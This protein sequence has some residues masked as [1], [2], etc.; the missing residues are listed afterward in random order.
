VIIES[1]RYRRRSNTL[2]T[3]YEF[4]D[5]L[6]LLS[7]CTP[8]KKRC[9]N[10]TPRVYINILLRYCVCAQTHFYRLMCSRRS[11]K[12]RASINTHHMCVCAIFFCYQ[13][14]GQRGEE[15]HITTTLLLQSRRVTRRS[16]AAWPKATDR[17]AGSGGGGGGRRGYKNG[18][19]VLHLIPSRR[20]F[21]PGCSASARN[22]GRTVLLLQ[23]DSVYLNQTLLIFSD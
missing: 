8:D 17:P 15:A 19:R 3:Q 20:N 12:A 5:N 16:K 2:C 22:S 6:V 18:N 4:S 23:A 1:D 10:T 14:H 11:G 7:T 9:R 13:W 21:N